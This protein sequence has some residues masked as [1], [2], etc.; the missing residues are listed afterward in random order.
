M[1]Y[2]DNLLE[3]EFILIYHMR[4]GFDDVQGMPV[5]ERKWL[6]DRFVEQK[7]KEN[8]EIKNASRKGRSG[9]PRGMR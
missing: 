1:K 2:R 9:T 4:Q 8:E 6:I 3:E 5:A 7:T